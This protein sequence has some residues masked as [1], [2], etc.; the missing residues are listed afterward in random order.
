MPYLLAIAIGPVQDFIAAARRT[1]DLQAG[2]ELLVEIAKKIA[3]TI[4]PREQSDAELIFPAYS[5]ENGKRDIPDG[6]NKILA[7]V[8][9]GDPKALA[10]RA[11]N[12]ANQ[13]LHTTWDDVRKGLTKSQ[14]AVL[15]FQD[16]MIAGQINHFLEFYAA[17]YPLNEDC[18]DYKEAR[19]A[20]ELLLAGR[21][22]LRE[23][24]TPSPCSRPKSPLDP[25]RDCIFKTER[26]EH[27]VPPACRIAPLYLKETETLD[28]IS[29]IK[30]VRG[31]NNR[32]SGS[33]KT[34]STSEM[35]LRAILPLLDANAPIE[36]TT[37][38][39]LAGE[40]GA[41]ADVSDFFF[42]G[43]RDE[44]KEELKAAKNEPN[45]EKWR[46]AE[47]AAQSALSAVNLSECP[48]Y[49]AVLV[50]DGDRMGRFLSELKEVK[51]HQDFSRGLSA[52]AGEAKKIVSGQ[53][54]HLIYSGG[55]DVMALL[56]VI[57]VLDCAKELASKFLE[58]LEGSEQRGGT[59]SVGVAI[60]HYMESLQQAIGYARQM[61]QMAKQQRNSLAVGLYKRG[62]EAMSVS[63]QWRATPDVTIWHTLTDVMRDDLSRGFPYELRNLAREWRDSE[64]P[65]EDLVNE[66]I[67]I[68]E[69]KKGG[70]KEK[71]SAS[72]QE[73]KEIIGGFIRVEKQAVAAAERPDQKDLSAPG[74]AD[75]VEKLAFKL[76]I[77]R[78]LASYPELPASQESQITRT[79]G[80]VQ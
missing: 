33:K 47:R 36:M 38:R 75:E 55:D 35:A 73:L 45:E 21:K 31:Y 40:F 23:F 44:L 63:D 24:G 54:G 74:P 65:A 19:Q 39:R 30:R 5:E 15:D 56:P 34:P 57:T 29:V 46:Q 37:I 8:Q 4:A 13:L 48:A 18:S 27:R 25:S 49:Y 6:P 76:V 10:E 51:A 70:E 68:L 16:G 62:G 69:R 43:R 53:D 12:T 2:S 22:A 59:L 17:W 14:E 64:L 60:V 7:L 52:F 71:E 58:T 41:Q 28:A 9:R 20:V 11:K 50:A 1:D 78:F 79:G 77:A 42:E 67:R 26:S 72:V 3:E 61:E 32:S 80:S 66:V